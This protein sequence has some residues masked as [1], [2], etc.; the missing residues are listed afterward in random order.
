MEQLIDIDDERVRV[1]IVGIGPTVVFIHGWALDLDMWTPQFKAFASSY[2][3]IAFD[4]RGFGL[5]SGKPGIEHDMNDI[6]ALLAALDIRQAALVGMSQGA[7]VATRWALQNPQRVSRIVLDGVPC[8][9]LNEIPLDEY[10]ALARREGMGAVRR[11]WLEHPFTQLR[12]NDAYL[13]ALLQKIVARYPGND[14]AVDEPLSPVADL[15]ALDIPVLVVNGEHD[16]EQRRA[17]GAALASALQNATHALIPQA[18]HLP[19]LDN[20][21]AYNQLLKSFLREPAH[22]ERAQCRVK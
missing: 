6:D 8:E 7:R 10:R 17:A 13:S 22:L 14:L 19:N 18:G 16:S 9:G 12:G 2:R 20:A 5:S 1:R 4:R 15:S 11:R 3:C 21:P